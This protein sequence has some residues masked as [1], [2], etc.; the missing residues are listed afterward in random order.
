MFIELANR[1]GAK[2]MIW[3]YDPIVITDRYNFQYHIGAFSRL[4]KILEG[5]TKKCVISFVTE[6]KSVT[7]KL[8]A[9][10]IKTLEKSYKIQL[11][12]EFLNIAKE[13]EIELCACCELPELYTLGVRAA[14][15]MEI[16]NHSSLSVTR[17]YLGVT[18]DDKDSAYLG[19]RL[20]S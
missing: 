20:I 12:M 17:R 18:Q 7:K 16:Y 14:V 3:R 8:Q 15:I 1:I 6:Y 11:V 13:H 5:S 2:R 9:I 10:G 4:C 19:L